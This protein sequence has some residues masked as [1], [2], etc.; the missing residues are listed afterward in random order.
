MQWLWSGLAKLPRR[1]DNFLKI[2]S[3]VQETLLAIHIIHEA[4]G[5]ETDAAPEQV[6]CARKIQNLSKEILGR[7]AVVPAENL[8]DEDDEED[9]ALE[10]YELFRTSWGIY[11]ATSVGFS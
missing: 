2:Q 11:S 7:L 10:P 3:Q 5:D 1:L 6:D 9:E 4:E 8:D